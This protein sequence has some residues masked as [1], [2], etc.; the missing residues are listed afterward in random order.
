MSNM[1]DK[2]EQFCFAWFT[3]EVMRK[4]RMGVMD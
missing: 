2:Q 3:I 1:P 4:V